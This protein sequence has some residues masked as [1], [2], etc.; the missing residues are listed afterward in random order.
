MVVSDKLQ[1]GEELDRVSVCWSGG[2]TR[3]MMTADGRVRRMQ[4]LGR[5]VNRAELD[6]LLLELRDVHECEG[7]RG[8]AC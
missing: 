3:A 5:F 1:D 4:E 2:L 8:L 7:P 6:R